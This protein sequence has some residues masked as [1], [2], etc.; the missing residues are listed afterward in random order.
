MRGVTLVELVVTMAVLAI[1]MFAVAP[2]VISIMSNSRVRSSAEA[3]SAGLQR[4]RVEAMRRNERVSFWIMTGNASNVLDDSC[5]PAANGS[6]WVVSADDPS[7]GC[8][9]DPSDTAAP[10]IKAKHDGGAPSSTIAIAA[11][12][13]D[14]ATTATNVVFD[15][16]GRIAGAGMRFVDIASASTGSDSRALRIELTTSGVVR[17]CEPLIAATGT[18]PRRCL[19][20]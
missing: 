16:Y 8:S 14:R 17:V 18:D 10:R 9:A 19:F 5:A 13:A 20:S 6:S 11:T 3:M 7:G 15:G 1:L 12:Q 2:D 4:A